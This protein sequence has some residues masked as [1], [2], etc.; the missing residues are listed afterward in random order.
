M[1]TGVWGRSLVDT[2]NRPLDV[3]GNGIV[4][5]QALEADYKPADP[6]DLDGWAGFHNLPVKAGAP[7]DRVLDKF[8]DLYPRE[9]QA[10]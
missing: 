3:N 9:N 6:G 2:E 5:T 1:W 7:P 10:R 4:G 8:R